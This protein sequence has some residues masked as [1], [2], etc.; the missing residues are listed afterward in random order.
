M[1]LIRA[2]VLRSLESPRWLVSCGKMQEAA[3]VINH[4]SKMTTQITTSLVITFC[5]QSKRSLMVRYPLYT[6]FL[7]YYLAANGANFGE[8]TNYIKYRNWT[9]S[10]IVGIFGPTLSTIL[11]SS[12]WFKSKLSMLLTGITCAAFS[13]AFTSPRIAAQNLVFS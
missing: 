9:I 2:F 5:S 8:T 6:T 13:G 12:R 1:S 10:S 3:E 11:V 7:P 4:I